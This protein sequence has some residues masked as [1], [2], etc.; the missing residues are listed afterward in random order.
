MGDV[1]LMNKS[2]AEFRQLLRL[3]KPVFYHILEGIRS[4]VEYY[5]FLMF[6]L[7]FRS[8]VDSFT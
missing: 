4:H 7:H 5:R 1:V 8:N 6:W 2:D 3:S